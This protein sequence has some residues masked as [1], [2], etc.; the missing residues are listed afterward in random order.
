[1]SSIL[2]PNYPP[3]AR[4]SKEEMIAEAQGDGLGRSVPREPIY[5]DWQF[6]IIA[7]TFGAVIFGVVIGV[8]VTRNKTL[9][10]SDPAT[11]PPTTV[12]ANA[13]NST[14]DLNCE[15][16]KLDFADTSMK[17]TMSVKSD[18]SKIE[19]DYATAVLTKTYTSLLKNQLSAAAEEY[20]DPYCREVDSIVILS[21][22]LSTSDQTAESR[23]SSDCDGIL[24]LVFGVTGTFVGCEDTEFPGLF[25]SRRLLM[26]N[27][28]RRFL[29][30]DEAMCGACPD[31]S[32]SLGFPSPT[33]DTI[34][35]LLD[36][37]VS[38]LPAVCEI[39]DVSV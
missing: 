21:N 33:V 37:F 16:M 9:D 26:K 36:T 12:M 32:A 38:V 25:S 2:T 22:E 34:T 28:L 4:K 3:P 18:I 27:N 20:C 15:M 5:F 29:E 30:D 24:T 31:S 13:T 7:L 19:T 1:M 14:V 11:L 23:Q 17:V 6:C 35:E 10:T 8:I 39:T